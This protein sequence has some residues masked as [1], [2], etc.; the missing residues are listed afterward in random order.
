MEL[1][2]YV[3]TYLAQAILVT[4]FCC[5]PLGIPA[6]IFAARVNSRL[7]LGDVPGAQYFS[8]KAKTWCWI[9]FGVALT[10]IIIWLVFYLL[11]GITILFPGFD[12][13]V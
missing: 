11:L 1:K 9:A 2:S 3:P 6:I 8:Q 12:Q 4:I 10:I 5:L 7:I 13:A